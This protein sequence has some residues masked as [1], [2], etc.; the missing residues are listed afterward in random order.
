MMETLGQR[1]RAARTANNLT[2]QQVADHFGI[3]RESVAGW[4]AD[5]SKPDSSRLSGLVSLFKCSFDWL[6]AGKGEPPGQ[7]PKPGKPPNEA[8]ETEVVTP[9]PY[10]GPPLNPQGQRQIP[11]FAAAQGGSGH[12]LITFDAIEY[13]PPPPE[14][15]N[16]RNTYGVLI[17]GESMVPAFRPGD[18]AWVNPNKLPERDSDVILYHVPPAAEAEAIIKT[19]VSFTQRDWRLRQYNPPREWD[20]PRE[21][22]PHC[23]RIVGKKSVR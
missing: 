15:V 21:D 2:Q 10:G 18:I 9:I 6:L 20:E 19:L 4:E 11:I 13:L 12:H 5:D 14:L 3:K 16:V 7:Q 23:H 8:V 22:W 1:I 17:K